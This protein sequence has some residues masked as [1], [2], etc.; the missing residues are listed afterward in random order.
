[1][2]KADLMLKIS[3]EAEITKRQA[4]KALD[5]LVEGVQEALIKGDNITL[6]GFGTFSV[7]SRSARK[8]RNPQT[9][10]EILIPVARQRSLEQEKVCGRQSDKVVAGPSRHPLSQTPVTTVRRAK[11]AFRPSACGLGMMSPVVPRRRSSCS[12]NG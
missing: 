7:M 3:K 2:N 8:G 4:A 12:T 5:A 1:V 10:R 9:G 11:I 6:M